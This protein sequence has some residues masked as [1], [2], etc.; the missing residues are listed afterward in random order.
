VG[1]VLQVAVLGVVL[2]GSGRSS[3]EG[4]LLGA[5]G[6]P[7]Q[8]RWSPTFWGTNPKGLPPSGTGKRAQQ[9]WGHGP[10]KLRPSCPLDPHVDVVGGGLGGSQ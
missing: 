7:F 8:G 6:E 2:D 9:R 4:F 5:V 10:R 1:Q 3:G